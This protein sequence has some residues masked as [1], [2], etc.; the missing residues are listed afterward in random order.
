MDVAAVLLF[1]IH[2]AAN[3]QKQR[4]ENWEEAI[5]VA[6]AVEVDGAKEHS[7]AWK[8]MVALPFCVLDN[9]C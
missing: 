3:V 1:S 5:F 6:V 9:H 2:S 8:T 7:V 4:G